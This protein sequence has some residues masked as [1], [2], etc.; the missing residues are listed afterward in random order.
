MDN[1]DS[2]RPQLAPRMRKT[3]DSSHGNHKENVRCG[4]LGLDVEGML[5]AGLAQNA[6]SSHEQSSKLL[7]LVWDNG[8]TACLAA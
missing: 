3:L 6:L 7:T 1:A 8:I 2:R 5:A 4:S